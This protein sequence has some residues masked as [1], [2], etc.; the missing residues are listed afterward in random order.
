MA[1]ARLSG[2]VKH[3]FWKLKWWLVTLLLSL[4]VI[5][6]A[7]LP[8]VFTAGTVISSAQVNQNFAALDQRLAALESGPTV[9]L[10]MDAVPGPLGTTG[11]TG[12]FQ[13]GGG[14]LL[15]TAAASSYSPNAGALI[16]VV[17]ELDGAPIGHLT[18]YTNESLSHKAFPPRTLFLRAG[19]TPDAGVPAPT[20]G[21]HTLSLLN[22]NAVTT[23]DSNDTFSVTV[24]EFPR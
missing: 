3:E 7:S 17:L 5:A 19:A 18:T 12:T 21:M 2:G 8:N 13:S 16:D 1:G 11:L 10:A 9:T 15:I 6:V 14:S 24:V 4:P 23:N 22:G 20:A